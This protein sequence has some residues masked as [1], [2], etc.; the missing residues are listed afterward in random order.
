MTKEIKKPFDVTL[1]EYE[2]EIE[3]KLEKARRLSPKEEKKEIES[4]MKAAANYKRR[5]KEERISIRVFANDL[6]KIKDIA[7]DEGLAYQTL[8]TSILHKFAAGRL[9]DVKDNHR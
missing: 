8:I 2:Q 7:D 3:D 9:K 6:K 4:A 5:K 1:D